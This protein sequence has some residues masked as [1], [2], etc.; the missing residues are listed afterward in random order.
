MRTR[1]PLASRIYN[2]LENERCLDL[3]YRF[4]NPDLI[5]SLKL[6]NYKVMRQVALHKR[7]GRW[8]QL[9]ILAAQVAVPIFAVVAWIAALV[10]SLTGRPPQRASMVH[11]IATTPNNLALV[12]AALSGREEIAGEYDAQLR[13][14]KRLS[15]EL[16]PRGVA[17]CVKA[18]I[19]LFGRILAL[20]SGQR[21]D[22][23]LH[24]RDAFGLIMMS[25][26]AETH[27]DHFFVTDDHYQRWAYLLSHSSPRCVLVQHGF[28][29][30]GIEFE[31]PFG[32]VKT[33]FLRDSSFRKCFER[34]FAV[35]SFSEFAAVKS[36]KQN[37]FA[38]RA[39]FLASSFPSIDLEIQLL[40]QVLARVDVPVIIKLHPAHTY[41]DRK[42]VLTALA[43]H[44]CSGNE[45]P[46][47][48]VFVSAGSFM[49]FDYR[50]L[51]R[52]T[53]S[54][55]RFSNVE[56]AADAVATYLAG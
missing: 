13:S 43:S 39:L 56:S 48:R 1:L 51:G 29:D 3:R 41:D 55:S 23:V 45:Y 53:F 46:D 26:F 30:S 47:C 49:E 15:A 54:I 18:H 25:H 27:P 35:A 22:M 8:Y 16:G 37:A 32:A 42:N 2:A 31:N 17:R 7:L 10:L 33:V 28:L 11:V 14:L 34:Y 5:N 36:L 12:E 24:A 52:T 44:V 50:A 4:L 20:P 40:R 9:F 38:G 21:K 6:P 19:V